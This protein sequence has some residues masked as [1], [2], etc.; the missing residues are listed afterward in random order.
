MAM[1]RD[2]DILPLIGSENPILTN[3]PTPALWYSS[4]SPLQPSSMDLHIGKIF[5]PAATGKEN[6]ETQG[7]DDGYSLPP[8]GT[9]VVST[10]EEVHLPSNLAG[11]AFPASRVCFRGILM[12]N[13][14]HV[15]PGY[16]GPLR[17]TIINMGREHYPIECGGVIATL[18]LFRLESAVCQ[19][20]SQR[21]SG[22]KGKPPTSKDAN[23]LSHD[24]LEVDERAKKE[25]NNVLWKGGV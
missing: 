6:E 25:A 14:G 5:L 15:D 7:R 4:N 21:N 23:R 13:P 19:D 12:T 8:G 17:F 3:V 9:V 22:K 24:F 1:L 18:L 2:Q 10:L 11:I 16:S 20:W